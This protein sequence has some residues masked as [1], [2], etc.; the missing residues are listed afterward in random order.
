MGK[1]SSIPKAY[2]ILPAKAVNTGLLF[3]L[4]L[5]AN[6]KIS[7]RVKNFS[8][9]DLLDFLIAAKQPEGVLQIFEGN[10]L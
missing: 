1:N 7:Q 4:I 3:V 10:F 9:R 5:Q 8:A 2:F 6:M